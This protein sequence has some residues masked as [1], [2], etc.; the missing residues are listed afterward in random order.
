MP[1]AII[2]M[3]A[4]IV[5]P[6]IPQSLPITSRTPMKLIHLVMISM[7]LRKSMRCRPSSKPEKQ[8]KT[9]EV[10]IMVNAKNIDMRAV[11]P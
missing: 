8:E 7:P 2:L 10:H 6:I 5:K 4:L 9:L 11:L 3:E 1:L